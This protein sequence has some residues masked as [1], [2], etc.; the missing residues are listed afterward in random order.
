MSSCI[1]T[2][3]IIG[4]S[5]HMLQNL[6]CVKVLAHLQTECSNEVEFVSPA[7]TKVDANAS[8]TERDFGGFDTLGCLLM[9]NGANVVQAH[10]HYV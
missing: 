7:K 2:N 3:I 8:S 5:L 10:V 1:L 4:S 6:V 9:M